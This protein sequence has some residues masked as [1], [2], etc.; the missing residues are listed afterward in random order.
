MI[1]LICF[2]ANLSHDYF[3]NRQDRYVLVKDCKPLADFF[4]G[5]IDILCS[6]SLQ[7]THSDNTIPPV[8]YH[9]YEKLN[10]YTNELRKRLSDYYESFINKNGK[11]EGIFLFFL[12]S[13]FFIEMC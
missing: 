13:N 6:M 3:T 7:L 10:L 8:K 12:F 9:P 1:E 2:R 4:E 5:M 11:V